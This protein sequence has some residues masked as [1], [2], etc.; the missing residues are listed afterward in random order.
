L[1]QQG[2]KRSARRAANV[3][4]VTV[5]LRGVAQAASAVPEGPLELSMPD[6]ATAGELLSELADRLPDPLRSALL[7]LGDTL[8][9]R[10][11]LFIDGQMAG[12]R[13]QR[14]FGGGARR[15]RVVVV[16]ESPVSGG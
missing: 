9:T 14:L 11:R 8:P 5:K 12:S 16:L 13:D 6:A 3:V 15:A 2:A 1:Q 10:L 7:P 4:E